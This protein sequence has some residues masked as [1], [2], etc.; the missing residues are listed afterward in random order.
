MQVLLIRNPAM[1]GFCMHWPRG[2]IMFRKIILLLLLGAFVLGSAAAFDGYVDIINETGYTI[3]Y[4][5]VSH[6][7]SEDWEDDVLGDEVLSDG[8]TY[9]VRLNGYPD[10]IFDILI[11]DEDGDTYTFWGVDVSVED[12]TVTIADMDMYDD[13]DPAPNETIKEYNKNGS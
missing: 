8:E 4:I 12:V 10:S 5:Y 3:F 6:H 13:D 11:E 2:G 7:S 9:R 1:T